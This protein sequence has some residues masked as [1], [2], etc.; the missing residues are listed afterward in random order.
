MA[1][2]HRSSGRRA[3]TLRTRCAGIHLQGV[4]GG[5][6]VDRHRVTARETTEA[7]VP[8][9][10][11]TQETVEAEIPERIRSEMA[12]DGLQIA[13]MRDQAFAL[14]HVDAEMAGVSD[15]RSGDPKVNG[16]RATA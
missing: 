11:R 14:T 6:G 16:G 15:W 8:L 12:T 1:S 9:A 10:R 13:T 3:H 5:R 2:T 4:F 7:A